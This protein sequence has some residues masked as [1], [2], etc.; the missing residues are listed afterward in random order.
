[1]LSY[2]YDLHLLRRQFDNVKRIFKTV[3]EMPGSLVQNIQKLFFLSVE[4]SKQY[5]SIIFFACIRFETSK[6]RVQHL[7]FPVLRQCTEV[8]MESWTYT[9]TGWYEF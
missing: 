8:I 2:V 1:M 7:S 5:A 9:V 6:R 4:L 3:E